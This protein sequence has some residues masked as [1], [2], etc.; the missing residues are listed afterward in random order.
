VFI[1]EILANMTQV[2]DVA[3]GPLVSKQV[4]FQ[5]TIFIDCVKKGERGRRKFESHSNGHTT[6]VA[7]ISV[8]ITL[9][10]FLTFFTVI[11]FVGFFSMI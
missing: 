9:Q 10:V 3:P 4:H 8:I 7:K 5:L 1:G 11:T 6:D 2:S